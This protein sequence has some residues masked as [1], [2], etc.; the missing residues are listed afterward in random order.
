VATE[1]AQA[2]R[3]VSAEATWWGDCANTYHEEQK[4][5]VYARQMGLAADWN[6]GHPPTFHLD[7]KS[8]LDLGGGPV[9]L[10]LKTDGGAK[11][12][13]A[14]AVVDPARYPKWVGARYRA[15]GISLYEHEAETWRAERRYDEAWIYNVLQHVRDP[16]AVIETAA[17][18]ADRLRIFEWVNVPTDELHGHR[19]T[20]ETLEEWIGAKGVVA[21]FDES[22]AVGAAFFGIFGQ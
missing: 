10:L 22:G 6:T 11:G 13:G 15:H 20:K 14:L 1:D 9:S 3:A 7:G 19:L 21:R 17:A 4:Q 12:R 8:I 18:Q 16:E 2:K 5:L